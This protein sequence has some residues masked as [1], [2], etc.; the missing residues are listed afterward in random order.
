MARYVSFQHAGIPQLTRGRQAKVGLCEDTVLGNLVVLKEAD[1]GCEADIIREEAIIRRLG[2]HKNLVEFVEA[3]RDTSEPY[4]LVFRHCSGGD[5]FE[6]LRGQKD[7]AG[8]P[9]CIVAS[10]AYQ[11]LSA[12]SYCQ[13]R[14]VSHLDVKLE[15][16]FV[17]ESG[18]LRLGDFGLS[19]AH[20]ANSSRLT[21][22]GKGTI[23]YMSPE[24]LHINRFGC[25]GEIDG[26]LADV[27]SFG[28]C[29]FAMLTGS[30]PYSC[31]S[32]PFYVALLEGDFLKFWQ[33]H[34]QCHKRVFD[35]ASAKDFIN[36][37]LVIDPAR[38]AR[39]EN[40]S[41][42]SWLDERVSASMLSRH[43]IITEHN[44]RLQIFEH[45][46]T[47]SCGSPQKRKPRNSDQQECRKRRKRK[48]LCSA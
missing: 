45:Q 7:E 8:F 21:C 10:F 32:D 42:H 3:L 36:R 43:P 5:L 40:L 17:E 24:M 15:N 35:E 38:R 20:T 41:K 46:P 47:T 22:S 12:L 27:W 14:G 25:E 9:A 37:C 39:M 4:R 48:R 11:T 30:F 1:R 44:E 13:S 26:E 18:R 16:I 31:T 33:L 2:P 28:V 29:C 19:A 34:E 23:M 6:M